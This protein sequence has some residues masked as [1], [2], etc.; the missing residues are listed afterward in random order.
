LGA[1]AGLSAIAIMIMASPALA[2]PPGTLTLFG[3]TGGT[4]APVAGPAVDSPIAYP[5]GVAV[6]GTSGDVYVSDNGN[7]VVDRITPDGTLSVVAGDGTSGMPT[8]G[9]AL[10]SHIGSP[11]SL[12]VDASGNLYI[13]DY[14]YSV[15][16]KVTPSG[17]LSIFA[18]NGTQG[19]PPTPGPATSSQL[20]NPVIAAEGD[21]VYIADAGNNVVEKVTPNGTL[22]IIAGNGT[23][24]APNPGPA[25]SSPLGGPDAV[26]VD[27]A[28]N[29]YIADPGNNVIEKVTPN[30]TLSI[31]A[32]NGSDGM[33]TP[34]PA[35]SSP[36]A[37]PNGLSVDSAGNL[38]IADTGD[39]NFDVEQIAEVT[40]NG[41]LSI[42]AGSGGYGTPT[43][44]V[45]AT[46]SHL[47]VPQAVAVGGDGAVYIAD[48]GSN[49]IE[50]VSPPVSVNTAAPTINGTPSVGQT[51]TAQA[52]TWFPT[53]TGYAYQWKD[54][55]PTGASCTPIAGA[56]ASTY[57]LAAA[58]SE[59]TIRVQV[60][61]SNESGSASAAAAQTALVQ[62]PATTTTPTTTT[63]PPLCQRPVR[64]SPSRNQ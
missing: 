34:G 41:T 1:A 38:Y 10:S 51:L 37:L 17:T 39:H 4:G 2:S 49:T 30:G 5:L 23:Q 20:S 60:T 11:S 53:P 56:N 57:T 33:P 24:G 7:S 50:R 46:S 13:V 61:A 43:Y 25:T 3:G 44:N 63:T 18:G 42:I 19:G 16:E 62:A 32:G 14:Q 15:V 54:C 55:D 29:V 35:T 21:D 12:A 58:D 64:R 31:I 40:P 59:H 52:G 22:S 26:A 27:A 47:A 45:P 6:S 9:P 48:E 8:A 28:G 36:L